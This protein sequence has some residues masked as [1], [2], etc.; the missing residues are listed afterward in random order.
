MILLWI[1]SIILSALFIFLKAWDMAVFGVCLLASSS[2][3]LA[4]SR[5]TRDQHK[6]DCAHA[7]FASGENHANQREASVNGCL[8]TFY[9]KKG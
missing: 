5:R 3:Q 1:V 7:L 8:L 2:I 9:R 6:K 4:R